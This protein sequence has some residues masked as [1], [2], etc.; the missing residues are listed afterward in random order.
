MKDE[1]I[2]KQKASIDYY[3]SEGVHSSLVKKIKSLE[4]EL[5]RL[6]QTISEKEKGMREINSVISQHKLTANVMTM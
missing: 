1:V 3:E 6:Y 4:E 2:R 5:N